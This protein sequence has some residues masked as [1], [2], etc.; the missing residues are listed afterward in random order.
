HHYHQHHQ[1]PLASSSSILPTSSL[2]DIVSLVMILLSLPHSISLGL[3][4]LHILLGSTFTG[5]KFIF[6][7]FIRENA[8][9]LV[10]NVRKF[11]LNAVKIAI[12]NLTLFGCLSVLIH[13]KSHFNYVIMFSKAIISS[14]LIG[15]SSINYINSISNKRI[16]SKIQYDDDKK[17]FNS[18]LINSVVSFC[19]INYI[20]YLIQWLNGSFDFIDNYSSNLSYI[21]NYNFS[22]YKNKL[23][24]VL[25][26]H[27]I[28]SSIFKKPHT[29]HNSISNV[30]DDI[31]INCD[32]N[33]LLDINLNE[34]IPKNFDSS[35]NVE[36]LNSVAIKNFENFIISPF[37]SRLT[38]LKN[39]TQLSN[40]QSGT[41]NN[42]STTSTTTA[43][44]TTSTSTSLTTT[45]VSPNIT[46]IENTIIIQPFW[47]ILAACK[48]IL[49]NPNLFLG[50]T[51]KFKNNGG[52]FIKIQDDHIYKS[53][54]F[55]GCKMATMLIDDSKV[56]FKFLDQDELKGLKIRN[57]KIKLNN[58]N[59][60]YFKLIKTDDNDLKLVIYGL[61]PLFQYE[62]D[63]IIE[64]QIVNHFIINTTND[65]DNL[66][67]NKSLA[68]TSSLKTLQIS[69]ISSIKNL[70]SLRAKLKKFKREENK[71]LTE[72][73]NN[74]DNL[75]N[76][77]SKYSS[78]LNSD[79]R[80]YG[81]LKGLK[82]S[83]MQLEQEIEQLNVT[84]DTL[85]EK[86]KETKS[87][88]ES[89]EETLLKEISELESIFIEYENR[90][91]VEKAYL[92]NA[93]SD[94]HTI[95]LKNQKLLNKQAA[96][97]E[98]IKNMKNDLKLIKKN[99]ILAKFSKRSKKTNEKYD[100]ILPKVKLE[101]E[102]LKED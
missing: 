86:E 36:S 78:K 52:K 53:K 51:T 25:S 74:I 24:L 77:I 85:H 76:K 91:K 45:T 11:L 66:V 57:L 29:V 28:S 37:N 87:G 55:E 4:I 56:I 59:W 81:K 49:K 62:I 67:L 33:K 2:R 31:S 27:I 9:P 7:I 75:K 20:N 35:K 63:L 30:F 12:L 61:T 101:T 68:E 83:V 38:I 96:R 79:Q 65:N 39:K 13:K 3:L 43:S 84:I 10:G 98:E 23:Y 70:S 22:N 19:I 1:Y 5:G 82:H 26:V 21:N 95:E 6:N 34:S 15:S 72:A 94:E 54:N 73:K 92:K 64:D 42:T 88:F 18:S 97:T 17:Y 102:I 89:E 50:E 41:T 46:T 100:T 93:K 90:I 44:S 32:E 8:E 71:K 48:A 69:L 80:A 58:V 16:S 40:G 60:T 47:S 99:E 14:D